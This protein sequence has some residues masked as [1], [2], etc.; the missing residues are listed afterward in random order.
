MIR[1]M[2]ELAR[3]YVIQGHYEDA[4]ALFT[5]GIA[6]GDRV[7]A[8]KDHPYTLRHVNGLGVLRT[9]QGR[10]EE[11]EALFN[12]ALEGRKL[13]LGEEHPYVFETINDLGLLRREQQCYQE[14]ESLLTEAL[15]RRMA[16]LGRDHPHSLESLHEL[17]VL[18][19]AQ[20]HY[21]DA[22]RR[23]L[24]AL[25][26][27]EAKFGPEHPQTTNSLR[28]LARL[29]ES[30]SKPNKAEEYRVRLPQVKPNMGHDRPVLIG[31]DTFASVGKM[32][33][34]DT[35]D[36]YT[37][38]GSGRDIRDKADQFHYAHKRLNGDG[39]IKARIESVEHLSEWTKVGVMIRETTDANSAFAV[40][41]I[42]PQ[43][44]VCFEYRSAA[45]EDTI[46]I[47]SDPNAIILP[48]WIR[49]LREGNI[50]KPQYSED[51]RKW[52]SVKSLSTVSMGSSRS[53]VATID[54]SESVLIG[55]SVC[56][57]AGPGIPAEARISNL[58]LTG[59]VD[60]P[61]EFLA[62]EAIGFKVR[63]LSD[64]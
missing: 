61:G 48:C 6:M 51:G 16:K 63:E 33:Y 25:H 21:E 8:G 17:G 32:T 30:W 34:D 44:R 23:L 64:Q 13:K 4:E 39:S 56:S 7:L 60:P 20:S 47:N 41:N 40:V 28:E 50:F 1:C 53:A 29:Y 5:E 14:A 22:E 3:L 9:K 26:G 12:R 46:A 35:N 45:G 36:T 15:K 58:T 59:S 38:L 27:R 18:Y 57:A 55:L 37:I 31:F 10:Y 62:F 54:M 11:A 19:L 24:E 42:T 49:L 52:K 43:N 2:N